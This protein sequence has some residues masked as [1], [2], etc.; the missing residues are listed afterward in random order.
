MLTNRLGLPDGIVAA[1][2]N[3]PYTRGNS[4]ISVTQLIQPP[5]Q[6]QLRETSEVIEDVSDRIWSLIGQATHTILERA[7]RPAPG[8]RVEERLYTEVAGWKVSGQFDVIEHGCLMDYKITSVWSVKGDT[9]LEWEQQLNLLRL[10]AIRNGIDVHRLRIIAILRDWTKVKAR[11]DSTYPQAQVVPVEIDVWPMAKTEAYLLERVKAHQAEN[12]PPCTDAERWKTEDVYA[13]MKDGRKSA[14]K[15]HDSAQPAVK[16]ATD[17]GKGH[18]VV[19]RP[20]EYRRCGEYCNVAHAC[21][22]FSAEVPF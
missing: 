8:C 3:D 13:V 11:T 5:Y 4:D 22:T 19:K 14:V 15:L 17:L 1:V 12:P 10:L 7:F 9:K 2:S 18:S 20:G 6:R 21:P 16:Q